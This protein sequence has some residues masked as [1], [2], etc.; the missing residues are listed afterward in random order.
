MA[1]NIFENLTDEE[2]T[3]VW[4]HMIFNK[5]KIIAEMERLTKE[6]EE[7]GMT[8]TEYLDS[9]SPLN[10]TEKPSFWWKCEQCGKLIPY[11]SDFCHECAYKLL[12]EPPKPFEPPKIESEE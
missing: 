1:D 5:D 2:Q 6:A 12:G 8:L 10:D 3:L 7:S 4:M 11:M 9:I